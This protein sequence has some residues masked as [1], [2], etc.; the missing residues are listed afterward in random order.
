M[1]ASAGVVTNNAIAVIVFFKI[2]SPLR[3]QEWRG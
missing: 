2:G 3:L 1:S